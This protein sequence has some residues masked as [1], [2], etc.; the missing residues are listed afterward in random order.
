MSKGCIV[1][2]ND[3][4]KAFDTKIEPKSSIILVSEDSMPKATSEDISV[5]MA[6]LYQWK[7]FWTE[8]DVESYLKFFMVSSQGINFQRKFLLVTRVFH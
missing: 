8:N 1:M 5:I 6:S 4:I 2:E 7:K 3:I